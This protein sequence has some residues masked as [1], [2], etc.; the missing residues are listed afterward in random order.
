MQSSLLCATISKH[1]KMISLGGLFQTQDM[2][3]FLGKGF[4]K[5]NLLRNKKVREDDMHEKLSSN[6]AIL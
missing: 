4:E 1:Y 2:M 3:H 6:L 5:N